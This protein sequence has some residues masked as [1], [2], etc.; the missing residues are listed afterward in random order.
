MCSINDPL[1]FCC[2]DQ[3][4]QCKGEESIC[5]D[6]SIRECFNFDRWMPRV[7]YDSQVKSPRFFADAVGLVSVAK[8][9]IAYFLIHVKLLEAEYLVLIERY[10]LCRDARCRAQSV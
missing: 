10:H 5:Q 1:G 4:S 8:D 2:V 3:R 9:S 6:V 7:A